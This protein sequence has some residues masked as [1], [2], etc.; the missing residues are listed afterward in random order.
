MKFLVFIIL[1]SVN[2][3]AAN[4]AC[5][6]FNTQTRIAREAVK[7]LI[8]LADVPPV[9]VYYGGAE[10]NDSGYMTVNVQPHFKLTKDWYKVI[11]RNS[12]CRV[13]NV[14]LFLENLQ[15]E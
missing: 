3:F 2:S 1:I 15:L 7:S 6:D 5:T 4:S 9:E 8:A 13:V 12:D 11:I 10:S 14:S